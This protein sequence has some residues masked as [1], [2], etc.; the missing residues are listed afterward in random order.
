[1]PIDYRSSPGYKSPL[2]MKKDYS[3]NFHYDMQHYIGTAQVSIFQKERQSKLTVESTIDDIGMAFAAMDRFV[4][5]EEI[6]GFPIPEV[7]EQVKNIYRWGMEQFEGMEFPDDLERAKDLL[8]C[9]SK[10]I[11]RSR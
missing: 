8:S 1:M 6:D 3:S 4:E 7:L 11:P 2:Q 9:L 10:V 5:A